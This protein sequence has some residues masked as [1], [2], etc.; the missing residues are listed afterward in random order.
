[1]KFQYQIQKLSFSN[2]QSGT[3]KLNELGKAGWEF[4]FATA[5][6]N[7]IVVILQKEKKPV[8]RPPAKKKDK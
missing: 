1:M 5:K 8:G 3:D 4:K 6:D 7:A 2:V